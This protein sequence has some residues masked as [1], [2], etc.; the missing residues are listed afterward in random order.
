MVTWVLG[1]PITFKYAVQYAKD[2]HLL[3]D[4]DDVTDGQRYS[5]ALYDI[6]R[7]S[8]LIGG[9]R[10]IPVLCCWVKGS[11]RCVYGLYVDRDSKTAAIAE[12]RLRPSFL[13]PKECAAKLMGLLRTNDG[14]W[15][16]RYDDTDPQ[17]GDGDID[18]GWSVIGDEEGAGEECLDTD[19]L[20]DWSVIDHEEGES[21]GCSESIQVVDV[22][23]DGSRGGRSDD[24]VVVAQPE[25]NCRV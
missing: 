14:P 12:R 7:R 18:E 24:S 16:Y 25:E 2:F 1:F 5:S 15:W 3:D 4:D 17:E 11:I 10:D 21:E 23:G 13:P 22:S 8:G 9:D 6:K 20:E 19:P